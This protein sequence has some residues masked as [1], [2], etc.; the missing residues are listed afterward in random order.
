VAE[1]IRRGSICHATLPGGFGHESGTRLVLVISRNSVLEDTG[2]A[3][4]LPISSA[5][6]MLQYPL[7]WPVPDDLL[8]RRSWVLIRQPR[9]APLRALRDPAGRLDREQLDEVV[10]GLRRLIEDD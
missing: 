5:D 7:V 4:V 2:L 3:I 6:P 8:D 9:S 10:A 1:A